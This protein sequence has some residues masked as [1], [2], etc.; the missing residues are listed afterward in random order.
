MTFV[1]PGCGGIVFRYNED[2]KEGYY[3]ALCTDQYYGIYKYTSQS[4]EGTNLIGKNKFSTFI[5][6]SSGEQNVVSVVAQGGTIVLFV[7]GKQLEALNDTSFSEGIIGMTASTQ[8]KPTEIAFQDAKV[9][10]V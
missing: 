10:Q 6:G 2:R 3:F 8:T 7:N 9:W 4:Q 5:N 1:K